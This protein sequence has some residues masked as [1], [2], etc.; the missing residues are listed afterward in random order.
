MNIVDIISI[1]IIILGGLIGFKKGAIKSLVQLVGL[2]AI[3]IVSYQFKGM[4]ASVFISKLPFLNYGGG[5]EGLYAINFLIFEGAAFFIIFI[6]LYCVLNILINISGIIELFLKATIILEIPSK[7]IGAILGMIESIVFIFVAAFIM[8]QFGQTQKFIVE[9]KVAYKIVNRTPIVTDVFAKTIAASE[10]IYKT[11]SI[12][13]TIE[14]K[15]G[16][17]L[18][19]VRALIKYGIIDSK[20]AQEAVDNGKLHMNNVVIAS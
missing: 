13:S 18:N 2:V 10:E 3:T 20:D 19:I 4:L 8:L 14:D 5:L 1:I 17:N 6:L 7:I 11:V 9:S 12:N 16:A 15:T